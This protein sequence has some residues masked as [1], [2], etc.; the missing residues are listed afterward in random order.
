M[1]RI[2]TKKN[3]E[4]TG[5]KEP[6]KSQGALLAAKNH[7]KFPGS[8]L[9]SL[10]F[11]AAIFPDQMVSHKDPQKGVLIFPNPLAPLRGYFLVNRSS[12]IF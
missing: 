7:K 9:Y 1:C 4:V 6:Q 10:R 5:H 3:Q 11:F 2:F 8:S 12:Q